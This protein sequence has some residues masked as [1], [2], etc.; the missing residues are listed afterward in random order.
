MTSSTIT[1]SGILNS[2]AM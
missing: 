2:T 1:G